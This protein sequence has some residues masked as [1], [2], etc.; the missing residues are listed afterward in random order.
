MV[1]EGSVVLFFREA[2]L[3]VTMGALEGRARDTGL[4]VGANTHTHIL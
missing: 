3:G 2:V 4:A 1:L